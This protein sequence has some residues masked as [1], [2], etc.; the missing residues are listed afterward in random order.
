[1]KFNLCQ[2]TE[3]FVAD[4]QNLSQ[5]SDPIKIEHLNSL[6]HNW[7]LVE[8]IK[9]FKSIYSLYMHDIFA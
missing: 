2:V 9:K 8:W 5:I 3:L 4:I 7:Q 6:V 1:M